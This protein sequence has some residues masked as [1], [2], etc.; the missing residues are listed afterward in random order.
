MV[1]GQQKACLLEKVEIWSGDTD[2]SHTHSQTTEYRA[3]QLLLSIKFKLSHAILLFRI[4][5]LFGF[6]TL[7][8]KPEEEFNKI[9]TST[10]L[11]AYDRS[12][13]DKA[14][15]FCLLHF[16]KPDIAISARCI[17]VRK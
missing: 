3:T 13:Q 8:K 1:H 10:Y 9:Q 6:P 7:R 12:H 11:E 17:T 4:F 16:Q 14:C 5:H 15:F 2:A